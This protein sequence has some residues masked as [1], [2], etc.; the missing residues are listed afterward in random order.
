[1]K[2]FLWALILFGSQNLLA[3][4]PAQTFLDE[5]PDS[6]TMTVHL[7]NST[8]RSFVKKPSEEFLKLIIDVKRI[9]ATGIAAGVDSTQL[10]NLAEKL[11]ANGYTNSQ[12]FEEYEEFKDKAIVLVKN[13]ESKDAHYVILAGFEGWAAIIQVMGKP[14]LAYI[15]AI[16]ELDMKRIM[17][18]MKPQMK[19][20]EKKFKPKKD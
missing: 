7:Y 20:A 4:N 10:H 12:E 18:F 2:H 3:Q 9:S 5:L 17:G 15:N 14:N 8:L 6:T 11:K 1:M 16:E 19:E 13:P